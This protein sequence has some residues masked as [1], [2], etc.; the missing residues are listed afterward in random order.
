MHYCNIKMFCLIVILNLFLIVP[1]FSAEWVLEEKEANDPNALAIKIAQGYK[2]CEISCF[3]ELPTVEIAEK[4]LGSA[5][6]PLRADSLF[7]LTITSYTSM[8]RHINDGTIAVTSE[9]Y[10]KYDYRK[11]E[12]V[13]LVLNKGVDPNA[14]IAMRYYSLTSIPSVRL[15]ELLLKNKKPIALSKLFSLVMDVKEVP[16]KVE[17]V[18]WILDQ[19]VDP[20]E[21]RRVSSGLSRE[22][23]EVL[24]KNK[25][26]LTLSDLL[27][28]EISFRSDYDTESSKKQ[29]DTIGF[30]L[31]EGADPNE[32]ENFYSGIP[33]R[34]ICELLL[35]SQPRPLDAS[36]FLSLIF[37]PQPQDYTYDDVGMP[38][39]FYSS[40]KPETL[41][42]FIELGLKHRGDLNKV[43]SIFGAIRLGLVPF[44]L[45]NGMA[46]DKLLDLTVSYRFDSVYD[47]RKIGIDPK[48]L[49]SQLEKCTKERHSL[50]CYAIDKGARID[51][52]PW[53]RHIIDQKKEKFRSFAQH[54]F[55]DKVEAMLEKN[56]SLSAIFPNMFSRMSVEIGCCGG[57]TTLW[58]YPMILQH[59]VAS[60]FTPDWFEQQYSSV[61]DCNDKGSV[62]RDM[63]EFLSLAFLFQGEQSM[64]PG[65]VLRHLNV[66]TIKLEK[67]YSTFAIFNSEHELAHA[68]EKIAHDGELVYVIIPGH[69]MGVVKTGNSYPL[70]DV[71]SDGGV[72]NCNN[73]LDLA[74]RIYSSYYRR[75]VKGLWKGKYGSDLWLKNKEWVSTG[76]IVLGFDVI[77]S[78]GGSVSEY[79]S[80]DE[81]SRYQK[82]NFFW[83]KLF[84]SAVLRTDKELMKKYLQSLLHEKTASDEEKK[85]LDQIKLRLALELDDA[86]VVRSILTSDLSIDVNTPFKVTQDM[87]AGFD[88]CGF[89]NT[90]FLQ[91]VSLGAVNSVKVMFELNKI[92]NVN[93]TNEKLKKTALDMAL[94]SKGEQF[95]ELAT[96]LR[97]KGAKAISRQSGG[98]QCLVL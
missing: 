2:P 61:L 47:E 38:T 86:D 28:W 32:I 3:K 12:L 77:G 59:K 14:L 83:E 72:V 91:A 21:K 20:R 79:L 27:C 88:F 58:G 9:E 85:Y 60:K 66:S 45:E 35:T 37:R 65:D 54:Y 46:P 43:D 39:Y 97:S 52:Y 17:V 78:A 80:K 22:I 55:L 71:S 67:K 4:L 7:Y 92:K 19:G 30:L 26:P 94:E 34:D 69:I 1:L 5:V 13:G 76:R 16:G 90:R 53:V 63:R 89:D 49:K 23:C 6:S 70:L 24:L 51:M 81:E 8:D 11:C 42:S 95:E 33:S 48:K 64:L 84:V 62:N 93:Q 18:K 96:L 29:K 68:L 41:Q 44:L 75:F 40:M 15:C 98:L 50:I 57:F 25:K 82:F 87:D 74:Q 10:K 31:K 56:S 36:K 73:A